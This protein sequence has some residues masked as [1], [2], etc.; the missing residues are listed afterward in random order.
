[1]YRICRDVRVSIVKVYVNN[2]KIVGVIKMFAHLLFS[3]PAGYVAHDDN[4]V[5][6]MGRNMEL[7]IDPAEVNL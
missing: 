4:L 1:M 2:E 6:G 3:D 7:A 5:R